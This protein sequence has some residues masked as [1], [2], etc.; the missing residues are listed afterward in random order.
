MTSPTNDVL[1]RITIK[2][3]KGERGE[4]GEQGQ[5]VCFLNKSNDFLTLM[6]LRA[7]V[8]IGMT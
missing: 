4:R 6:K 8:R 5:K 7:S 2:G 3:E 1:N